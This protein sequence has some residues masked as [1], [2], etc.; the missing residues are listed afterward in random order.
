MASECRTPTGFRVP[1]HYLVI[2]GDRM[3]RI[4]TPE[5]LSRLE[6]W[7]EVQEEGREVLAL[8]LSRLAMTFPEE[9]KGIAR[10]VED[11]GGRDLLCR[12]VY[13]VIA[14]WDPSLLEGLGRYSYLMSWAWLATYSPEDFDIALERVLS[15]S[16]VVDEALIK[17][18]RRLRRVNP[19]KTYER[20]RGNPYLL[21]RV[22]S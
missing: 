11:C 18:L 16:Q 7:C 22:I 6:C 9:A 13:P 17:A 14:L 4:M 19:A 1:R 5:D 2:L 8:C 20:I 15:R 21:S 3:G 12:W 10:K